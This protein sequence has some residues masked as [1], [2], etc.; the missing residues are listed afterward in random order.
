MCALR[1]LRGLSVCTVFQVN[2][3]THWI[4]LL[5][6]HNKVSQTEQP[7]KQTFMFSQFLRRGAQGQDAGEF[8][9]W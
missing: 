1:L 4:S 9:F 5:S 7:E 2:P 3:G 6:L 8:G